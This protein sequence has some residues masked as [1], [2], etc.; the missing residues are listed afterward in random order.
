MIKSERFSSRIKFLPQ[1]LCD[2]D[3][4]SRK[5][6][7]HGFNDTTMDALEILQGCCNPS[8]NNKVFQFFSCL[9]VFK[10]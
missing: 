10:P 2:R 7:M 9:F 6:A 1:D 5:E 8:S 3:G 4:K